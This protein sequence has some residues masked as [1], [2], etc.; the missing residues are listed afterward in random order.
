MW[1]RAT[2]LLVS[3]GLGA[4]MCAGGEREARAIDDELVARHM[5]FGTVV[6]PVYASPVS[7]EITGYSR[8]GDSALWTAFYLAAEAF[9][10]HATH[11][12]EA[13]ERAGMAMAGLE[14][15][16][17]V[18]GTDTL[19]RAAVPAG[20]A[21]AAG[22]L[23]EEGHNGVYPGWLNG[24]AWKWVGGTSRDQYLGVFFGL[25]AA[26]ERVDDAAL[27]GRARQL[28]ARLTRRLLRDGWQIRMPGGESRTKFEFQ[29]DEQLA[30]LAVARRLKP[31]E[32]SAAYAR[33]AWMAPL[34]TAGVV[35]KTLDRHH[36]YY[37]FQL[38]AIDLY[39]LIRLEDS[40]ARRACYRAAFRALEVAV[41]A[42]GNPFLAMLERAVDGPIDGRDAQARRDLEAWLE[43]PRRDFPVDLRG[44]A[45]VC[46]SAGE[47]CA[48][49][50]VGER[51]PTD[52]LWQRSPYQSWGGGE[53]T[54]E[55]AGID[56][57][58]PYWM[59]QN[60]GGN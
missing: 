28:C 25:E 29:P 43:R 54:I 17:D 1:R 47:A 13:L 2:A 46:G 60:Y 16:V 55:G 27:Q 18:T 35:A 12:A 10:W 57:L 37:K 42:E 33:Y 31:D 19:A 53:G 9:R 45:A 3:I 49:V 14:E 24:A 32:F 51:V 21:M 8:G 39:D 30:L 5:P 20:A 40:S 15:L 6:D 44:S 59:G 48:M 23:R 41:P 38:A 52:F 7:G 11:D 34:V 36:N 58:L 26:S 4:G 50:P 22:M 56:Y